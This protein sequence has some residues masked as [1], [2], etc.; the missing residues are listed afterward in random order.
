MIGFLLSAYEGNESNKGNSA[1]GREFYSGIERVLLLAI[2]ED[3]VQAVFERLQ[4]G[5]NSS[6]IIDLTRVTSQFIW[7]A[8]SNLTGSRGG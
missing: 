3:E 4:S 5:D 2:E 7:V 8:H 1:R 6:F